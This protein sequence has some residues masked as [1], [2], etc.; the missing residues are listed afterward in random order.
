MSDNREF[1]SPLKERSGLVFRECLLLYSGGRC[2]EPA[3]R[4]HYPLTL[5]TA[6]TV[7]WAIRWWVPGSTDK[8]VPIDYVIQN[9][10]RIE[11]ITSQNSKG[12]S[13]DWLNIGE[14]HPGQEQDQPVVQE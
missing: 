9:G 11:I 14:E 3:Q 8:L 1:I 2:E 13:R 6:S 12:P 4:F 5:R 10:D 7:R